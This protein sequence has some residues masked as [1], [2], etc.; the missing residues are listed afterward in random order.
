MSNKNYRPHDKGNYVYKKLSDIMSHLMSND[1]DYRKEPRYCLNSES[2]TEHPKFLIKP[3]IVDIS[4]TGVLIR[5]DRKINGG[6]IS[7]D[8]IFKKVIEFTLHFNV[9]GKDLELLIKMNQKKNV[10]SVNGHFH[11]RFSLEE[12]QVEKLNFNT[13]SDNYPIKEASFSV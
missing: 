11:W 4:K 10:S 5:T 8:D 9:Q 2:K 12:D 3:Y 13:I 6:E 7:E 1:N